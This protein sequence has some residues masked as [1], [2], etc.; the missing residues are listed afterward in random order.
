MYHKF[1]FEETGHLDSARRHAIQTFRRPLAFGVTLVVGDFE[2]ARRR[3]A[4]P[5]VQLPEVGEKLGGKRCECHTQAHQGKNTPEV[6]PRFNLGGRV[7]ET[8]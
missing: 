6:V 2:R 3:L 4:T 1:I 7:K 5:V 8:S